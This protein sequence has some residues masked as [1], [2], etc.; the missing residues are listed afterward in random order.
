MHFSCA[1]KD[2]K[3]ASS[4]GRILVPTPAYPRYAELPPYLVARFDQVVPL[5]IQ[6]DLLRLFDGIVDAGAV[7]HDKNSARSE[8]V[9]Y[10][11]GTW[12]K[13][14]D[15]PYLTSDTSNQ[16]PLASQAIHTFM[17][18]VARHVAPIYARHLE[19]HFPRE[20]AQQKM[21]VSQPFDYLMTLIVV[22][23]NNRMCWLMRRQ[24]ALH[25]GSFNFGGVFFAMAVKE[26]GS[27]LMHIDWGDSKFTM[28]L[29]TSVGGLPVYLCLPQIKVK[30][31]LYPGQVLAVASRVLSH[32]AAHIETVNTDD[33][34][35]K[36]RR[37]VVV[38]FCDRDSIARSMDWEM[39][40][41]SW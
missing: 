40:E 10:H 11:I 17:A 22:S 39:K 21:Y 27:E 6:E 8:T 2:L 30:I 4:H 28:A 36:Q 29:I 15:G 5:R 1:L 35:P 41:F 16:S 3:T 9:S 7:V 24:L 37:V 20:F 34:V 19:E 38:G 18:Y 31:P 26:G 14:D 25:N 12:E 23:A 13:Y 32:F 33:S